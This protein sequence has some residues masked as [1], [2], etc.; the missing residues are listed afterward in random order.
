MAVPL[1]ERDAFLHTLDDL[2][3]QVET[4]QGRIPLVSGEAG[5]GKTSLVEAF[6]QQQP[7]ATR[8]LW[9]TCEALFTPRPLGPLYD[10]AYQTDSS[11]L[12]TLLEGEVNRATLF[13]AV[14]DDLSQPGSRPAIV[15]IEDIHWADEAT[16]DLVKFLSRR[17]HRTSVLL[18]LTYRDDELGKDHPLRLVLGDLPSGAVTRLHLPPLSEA[19]VAV[20]ARQAGRSSSSEELYAI[21]SGNPFFLIETLAS[22]SPGVASSVS[23]AVL[24][25]VA[26]CSPPAQRLLELV[27]VVP[28]RI[29]GWL[30]EAAEGAT[31]S[32][33]GTSM[34]EECLARGLLRVDAGMVRYRHELARQAVE[35]SLV[36]IR[37]RELHAQVLHLLLT[38]GEV[39]QRDSRRL[40]A[41]LVHHAAQAEDSRQVLRLAPLA[42]RQASTQGAHREAVAHYQRA[43]DHAGLLP[44]EERADLLDELASECYLYGQLEEAV[45]ARSVALEIWRSLNQT[46][47]IGHALRQLS[48]TLCFMERNEEAERCGMEAVELLETLPPSQDLALAYAN[49]SGQHMVVS[50]TANTI[51]WGERA[52]RLAEQLEDVETVCSVLNHI[53]CAEMDEGRSSGKDK[54]ARSLQLALEHEF[55]V[56]VARAY[57]NLSGLEIRCREY[58]EATRHLREGLAYSIEHD[59]RAYEYAM[60]ANWAQVRLDQGDWIGA[61]EDVTAILSVPQTSCNRI[62][63]LQILG[64]V[65]VRRGD[66]GAE[67]VLD[68][69]RDLALATEEMQYIAPVAAARAEWRWL[70]GDCERCVA[71]AEVGYR[72]AL[73]ANRPWAWGAAAIWL[74]QGG[75]LHDALEGTPRVFALQ[76]EG[77]W[78]GAA[79]AWEQLGCP[80]EQALALLDGGEAAQRQALEIFERLGARPAAARV[81]QRLRQA[82]VRRLP[83][84]PRPATQAN[85]RGLT[86]RQLEILRLLAEGLHNAEIADRLSTTTKTVDHHV[87]AV[88]AKLEAH[89]RTEAVRLASEQHLLSSPPNHAGTSAAPSR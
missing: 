17:I 39:E 24:T 83:R 46:Q 38:L 32:A 67:S 71:E 34:L 30:V 87:S 44:P 22:D 68:E 85:P 7:A 45:H 12:R 55:E 18:I 6:L 61:E 76:M 74:W 25:Q 1:L 5:I 53:G 29:E 62:P 82:G 37:R 59:M 80:Y 88:L 15:V 79:A 78:Q 72:M 14:L 54:L 2:L 48:Y 77:D 56:G 66:P 16:L 64:L 57:F 20:L 19:G 3:H 84:G 26:R 70:Q 75:G 65:R 63:A 58:A 8:V 51:L 21:T 43:L 60:R 27:S 33:Q 89:S 23:D 47:K 69:A 9:G 10:I 50:D 41:R 11:P 42:A 52:L 73:A 35:Y 49:L 36:P 28:G 31:G 13:A 81:R 4:G 86:A 40:L